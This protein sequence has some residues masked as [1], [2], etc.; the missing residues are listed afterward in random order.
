MKGERNPPDKCQLQSKWDYR[1]G[2]PKGPIAT[3][4]LSAEIHGR[5]LRKEAG[6]EQKVAKA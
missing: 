5:G 4:R 6:Q 1:K 3:V 2:L